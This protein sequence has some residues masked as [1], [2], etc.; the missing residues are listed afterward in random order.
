MRTTPR[1]DVARATIDL[2][3][4]R[5][6]PPPLPAFFR[7][8][9]ITS[10]GNCATCEETMGASELVITSNPSSSPG[11][12]KH[13]HLGCHISKNREVESYGS[14]ENLTAAQRKLVLDVVEPFREADQAKE[15]RKVARA[16][17]K[18]AKEHAAATPKKKAR[19]PRLTAHRSPLTLRQL[20]IHTPLAEREGRQE[21]QA[22]LRR[23]GRRGHADAEDEARTGAYWKPVREG[24]SSPHP[25]SVVAPAVSLSL[26]PPPTPHALPQVFGLPYAPPKYNDPDGWAAR[27]GTST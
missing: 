17:A 25:L 16:A 21:G 8:A 15:D 3:P 27:I 6:P 7:T 26:L 1:L 5:A 20:T 13:H 10:G 22:R 18:E 12:A 11:A 24:A 9:V 4:T 19:A 23:R 14:W 2:R